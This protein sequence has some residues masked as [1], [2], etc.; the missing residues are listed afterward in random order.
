MFRVP[1]HLLA[2]LTARGP[3][4]R[5]SR[6]DFQ[7]PNRITLVIFRRLACFAHDCPW[8]GHSWRFAQHSAALML[9]I[10]SS[11][12]FFFLSRARQFVNSP[13]VSFVSSTLQVWI[14]HSALYWTQAARGT[15]A[16]DWDSHEPIN[17]YTASSLGT[18]HSR[19]WPTQVREAGRGTFL[20]GIGGFSASCACLWAAW[21]RESGHSDE[22]DGSRVHLERARRTGTTRA[23]D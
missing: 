12:S 22:G 7:T 8:C 2:E 21:R 17:R 3:A 20:A 9:R 13:L 11:L 4:Q 1:S 19:R 10:R 18:E 15:H 14:T 16:A 23:R 5:S 6:T